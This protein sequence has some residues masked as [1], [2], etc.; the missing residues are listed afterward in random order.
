MNGRTFSDRNGENRVAERPRHDSLL[1]L[2]PSR[3]T[4]LRLRSLP[5]RAVPF[6]KFSTGCVVAQSYDQI[7]IKQGGKVIATRA[8]LGLISSNQ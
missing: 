7:A 2:L 8:R 6:G 4:L 5:C 3:P 1:A